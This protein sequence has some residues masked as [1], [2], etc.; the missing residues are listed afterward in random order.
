[1]V[2]DKKFGPL[3]VPV[4]GGREGVISSAAGQRAGFLENAPPMP[5]ISASPN[6]EAINELRLAD[7]EVMP[8]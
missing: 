2:I 5:P 1:M 7:D 6:T 4:L 3:I 8:F